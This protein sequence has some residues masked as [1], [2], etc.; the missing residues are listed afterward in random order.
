[1]T[2][3][4]IAPEHDAARQLEREIARRSKNLSHRALTRKNCCGRG[5]HLDKPY[6]KAGI[7]KDLH[8][9]V[10]M[11]V[12]YN[13]ICGIPLPQDALYHY[14]NARRAVEEMT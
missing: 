6:Q 9:L 4:P 11:M 3:C 7:T 1:M 5:R 8:V 10:G 12:A 13:I 2:L 14:D